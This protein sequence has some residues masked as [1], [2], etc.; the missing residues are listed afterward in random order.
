MQKLIDTELNG[1][2]KVVAIAP[3]PVDKLG[4]MAAKLEKELGKAPQITF[5]ADGDHAVIDAYGL[6]NETA[7][8]RNRFLPH[9]TTY[10]LDA[11]GLV[12]WKFTEVDYKVRPTNEMVLAEVRK[13]LGK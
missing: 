10:V 7:A 8:Q 6:L 5:L 11:K 2:A 12:R 9:P 1:K 4:Q 3:D 13:L